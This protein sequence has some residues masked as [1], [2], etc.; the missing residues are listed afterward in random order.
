MSTLIID[1][2][3]WHLIH[4]SCICTG[5]NDPHAGL[6]ERAQMVKRFFD[7]H[8]VGT[9]ISHPS[10]IQ[11]PSAIWG[12]RVADDLKHLVNLKTSFTRTGT[13]NENNLV[14]AEQSGSVDSEGKFDVKLAR[15]S[16]ALR[17]FGGDHTRV[18][19]TELSATFPRNKLW[20]GYVHK[21]YAIDTS[22]DE[23]IRMLRM[24]SNL[25]NFA[26]GVQLKRDLWR[27]IFTMHTF[28]VED[29]KKNG[30]IVSQEACTT[31]KQDLAYSSKLPMA[32]VGQMYQISKFMDPLWSKFEMVFTGNVA[33]NKFKVP[34][35]CGNF[36]HMAGI[37]DENIS[38]WLDLMITGTEQTRNF[39]THCINNKAQN[40]ILK[41]I[42]EMAGSMGGDE[43]PEFDEID[44]V[45]FCARYPV[46]TNEGF[47]ESW[48][49]AIGKLKQKHPLPAPLIQI[50]QQK[51]QV[52]VHE[53]KLSEVCR[54]ADIQ[55]S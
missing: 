51:L 2:R 44:W 25:D 38:H 13:V 6:D 50:I 9:F 39:K 19:L 14:I 52:D 15:E 47:I 45:E 41:K 12:A 23:S 42:A 11:G 40:R 31:M 37:P 33:N 49:P 20:A 53:N 55:T 43:W 17:S 24:K 46:T 26:A 3:F 10:E 35:S 1:I 48:V 29:M 4:I 36:V 21:T 7:D 30:G 34:K 16:Q 22:L 8:Y 54:H 28:L 27:I 18:V 5:K 32:S